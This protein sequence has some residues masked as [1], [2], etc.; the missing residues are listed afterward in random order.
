MTN[1]IENKIDAMIDKEREAAKGQALLN[2]RIQDLT[3][4]ANS[5]D[6]LAYANGYKKIIL[7]MI[8]NK[9]YAE[10]EANMTGIKKY[11]GFL[12]GLDAKR[13]A[14]NYVIPPTLSELFSA[15]N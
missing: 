13:K 15:M 5:L 7:S 1:D 3:K 9:K 11:N 6:N 8:E 10:A 2:I 14:G 12:A 4:Q